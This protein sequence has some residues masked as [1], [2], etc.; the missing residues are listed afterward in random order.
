MPQRYE[1]ACALLPRRLREAALAVGHRMKVA[2]VAGILYPY[3]SLCETFREACL[4]A[5]GQ[6]F[7]VT[8]LSGRSFGSL[9]REE[10]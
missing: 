9:G 3:P 8:N 6:A 10:A 5:A 4:S 1:A 2:D 7:H